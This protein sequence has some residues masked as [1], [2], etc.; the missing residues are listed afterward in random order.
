MSPTVILPPA[1]YSDRTGVGRKN[2]SPANLSGK[3]R[4]N[5]KKSGKSSYLL[6]CRTA[7]I[8]RTAGAAPLCGI[9]PP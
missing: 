9:Q 7:S 1:A 5:S 3:K 6:Y 2:G 4:A 8:R